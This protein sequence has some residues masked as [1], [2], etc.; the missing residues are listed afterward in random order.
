[1]EDDWFST[2]GQENALEGHIEPNRIESKFYIIGQ[3]KDRGLALWS[4]QKDK[5]TFFSSME[6]FFSYLFN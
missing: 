6:A 2:W 4:P 5:E 3:K 1:M